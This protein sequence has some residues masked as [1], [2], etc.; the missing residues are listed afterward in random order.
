M[1]H[2]VRTPRA[3]QSP[4]NHRAGA[5]RG[6]D[7]PG[8]PAGNG[9]T[10]G[11]GP[12]RPAPG[13]TRDLQF[14]VA[15]SLLQAPG[16]KRRNGRQSSTQVDAGQAEAP[17]GPPG[18]SGHPGGAATRPER[19]AGRS[20]RPERPAGRSTRPGRPPGRSAGRRG[21]AVLPGRAANRGIWSAGPRTLN[22]G[23]RH[24]SWPVEQRG[25]GKS[26]RSPIV[27]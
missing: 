14:P 17:R 3:D 26:Y 27:L 5:G 13:K 19:P 2:R 7:Q 25:Q 15:A 24:Y 21:D 8:D 1:A 18:R 11:P 10:A 20:T 6:R 23:K 12:P 4:T 22:S 9:V 16:H